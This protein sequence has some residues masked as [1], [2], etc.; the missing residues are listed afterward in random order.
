MY[1]EH[2][3]QKLFIEF[4]LL[5]YLSENGSDDIHFIQI[6]PV[7]LK[8][9]E[10]FDILK[11][12]FYE[13]DLYSIIR[14]KNTPTLD[15][16]ISIYNINDFFCNSENIKISEQKLSQFGFSINEREKKGLRKQY[17]DFMNATYLNYYNSETFKYETIV[18]YDK[19]EK[20]YDLHWDE[21]EFSSKNLNWKEV[22]FMASIIAFIHLWLIDI[23]V[24]WH[25]AWKVEDYKFTIKIKWN[26]LKVIKSLSKAQEAIL[27]SIFTE[28]Y[29]KIVIK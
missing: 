18:L 21:F 8:S 1:K 5:K 3:Q 26:L 13:R 28:K 4:H 29:E 24:T 9:K 12:I 15:L 7:W 16:N 14:F 23:L 19:L 2:L 6:N 20:L 22:C 10:V 17:E 27:S 25:N 11:D